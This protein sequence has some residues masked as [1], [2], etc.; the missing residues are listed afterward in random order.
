MRTAPKPAD[1]GDGRI[2][3]HS[4]AI[5]AGYPGVS[6]IKALVDC[7]ARPGMDGMNAGLFQAEAFRWPARRSLRAC[8]KTRLAR[9]VGEDF[10]CFVGT[11]RCSFPNLVARPH[12]AIKCVYSGR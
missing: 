7:K 3:K 8:N 5:P 2:I 10:D 4:R 9:F 1:L 11:R 12:S 6:T